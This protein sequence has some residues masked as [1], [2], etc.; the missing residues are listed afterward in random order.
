MSENP[1]VNSLSLG[2]QA[3]G[4]T[5]AI[6]YLNSC[7]SFLDSSSDPHKLVDMKVTT[8]LNRLS[9][10]YTYQVSVPLSH[11]YLSIN[12][13]ADKCEPSVII[14]ICNDT[15]LLCD[16][17]KGTR[18]AEKLSKSTQKL[19]Q[20]LLN[21]ELDNGQKE[22]VLSLL[23]KKDLVN[24]DQKIAEIVKHFEQNNIFGTHHMFDLFFLISYIFLDLLIKFMT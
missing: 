13:I 23:E 1:L 24:F 19:L 10:K 17:I 8:L 18:V 11:L 20:L 21:T 12:K 14:K 9:N 6:K 2:I 22:V 15:L 5:E 4:F 3:Q 16:L 7:R